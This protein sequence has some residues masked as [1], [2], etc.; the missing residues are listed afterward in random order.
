MDSMIK[1]VT[2]PA[3]SSGSNCSRIDAIDAIEKK[4]G[5]AM[6]LSGVLQE[7]AIA[8]QNNDGGAL[9][10]LGDLIEEARTLFRQV[11]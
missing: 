8:R 4:L 5:Q 1:L 10:V 7:L 11:C 9:A 6:D 3:A 2:T